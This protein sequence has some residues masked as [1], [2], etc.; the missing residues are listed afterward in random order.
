MGIMQE[1]GGHAGGA[2]QGLIGELYVVFPGGVRARVVR[3]EMGAALFAAGQV[4][5]NAAWREHAATY[6][7]LVVDQQSPNGYRF[8]LFEIRI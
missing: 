2:N 7:A 4:L 1:A 6:M 8:P 3:A 5:D